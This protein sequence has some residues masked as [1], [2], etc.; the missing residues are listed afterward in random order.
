M[1]SKTY[2]KL[3]PPACT[4]RELQRRSLSSAAGK[5]HKEEVE[6]LCAILHD[7]APALGLALFQ[8]CYRGHWSVARSIMKHPLADIN[9][10]DLR[11]NVPLHWVICITRDNVQLLQ[12]ALRADNKEDQ[13]RL[14]GACDVSDTDFYDNTAL[15]S[16]ISCSKYSNTPLSEA[17]RQNNVQEVCRLVF[18]RHVKV[19]MQ[20]HWDSTALHWACQLGGDDVVE[21]LLL[22]GADETIIQNGNVTAAQ[23]AA[24]YGRH[25]LLQLFD[26]SS[27]WNMLIRAYRLRRRAAARVMMTLVGYW[28][29]QSVVNNLFY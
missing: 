21:A 4:E 8:A 27:A 10:S 13:V 19:D 17:C 16:V 28:V 14:V 24:S 1:A 5:G 3:L 2:I 25:N 9:F 29:K 6:Q 18:L 11:S 26:T 12:D 23:V 22:A 20:D 7:D 15:H